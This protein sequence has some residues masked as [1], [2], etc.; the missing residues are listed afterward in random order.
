VLNTSGW[1][2]LNTPNTC[3]QLDTADD[4]CVNV[5]TLVSNY[6]LREVYKAG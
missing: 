1:Q 2:T 3:S 6:V 4:A 5:E